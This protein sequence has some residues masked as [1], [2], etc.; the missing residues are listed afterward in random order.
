M[1]V[2]EYWASTACRIAKPVLTNL[3]ART[4]RLRMPVEKKPGT[5]QERFTHLEAF[6]RL[7]TGLAPWLEL[8]EEES[9]PWTALTLQALDSI[10]DPASPDAGNFSEPGQPL[11]DAAFLA[12]ALMRAPN[13]VW[14]RSIQGSSTT[15]SGR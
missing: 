4:L 15:S 11:V 9:A 12:Q 3:A 14:A 2:R 8:G 13:A 6:A 5:H 7:L 1:K 10:T